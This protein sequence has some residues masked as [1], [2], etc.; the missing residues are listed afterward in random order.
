MDGRYKDGWY[1]HPNLGLIRIFLK[2]YDW[3]YQ[4]YTQNGSKPLSKE[5]ALDSWTWALSEPANI[6]PDRFV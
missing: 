4:C 5:R 3:F 6:D 1:T 2:D